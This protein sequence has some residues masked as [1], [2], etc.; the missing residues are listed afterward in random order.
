MMAMNLKMT[1]TTTKTKLESG[2]MKH[3]S[4]TIVSRHQSTSS[5]RNIEEG[6]AGEMGRGKQSSWVRFSL[7][8]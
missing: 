6:S 3:Q 2:M 7:V 5:Q 4:L 8:V 1:M